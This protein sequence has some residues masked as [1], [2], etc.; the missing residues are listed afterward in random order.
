VEVSGWQ[1]M[2]RLWYLSRDLAISGYSVTGPFPE[3]TTNGCSATDWFSAYRFVDDDDGDL[4]NGTPHADLIFSAFDL[5]ATAC[6]AAGDASNQSTGCPAPVAAP[7]LS[8]VCSTAPVQLTWTA[9]AGAARYRVLRNTLGCEFG[10]TPLATVSAGRTYFEDAEVAPGVTYYYSVQPVSSNPSCYGFASSCLAVATTACSAPGLS[11]PGG[12]AAAATADNEVTVSWNPVAGA[13]SYKVLRT[14]G[15]CGAAGPGEAVGVTAAPAPALVDRDDLVGGTAYGYRVVAS[16]ASCPSCASEPSS[17]VE[18][19]ATGE[20]TVA[21]QFAGVRSVVS[22][23]DGTCRLSVGWDA[24]T[25]R[26]GDAL[27]YSVYRSTDPGFAPAP[28]NLVASEVAGTGW[29]DYGVA[30]DTRYFYLVRAVDGFGNGDTNTVRRYEVPA[31]ALAPGSFSDDAGDTGSGGFI[32]A[33]APP[34]QWAQRDSDTGNATRVDATTAAGNYQ[35][36][37]CSAL[38]SPTLRL[39]ADPDLAFTTRYA[40]EQGWDG[41]IVQV[42]TE[43]GGFADWTRLDSV[44]YPGAMT[45]PLGDPACNIPEFADLQPV[46]TGTSGGLYQDNGG[47]LADWAGQAVRLRFLFSSDGAT[48]DEGWFLDDLSVD[49]VMVAASCT[50]L[51]PEP[52]TEEIDDLDEAVSYQGGW[53]RRTDA[54]ATGGGYHRRVGSRNGEPAPVAELTFAGDSITYLYVESNRGGTADVLIDGQLVDTVVYGPGGTGPE[55]PTFGHSRTWSGLGPGSHRLEI[56][57]R[58]GTVYVD[59]FRFDCSEPGAG[60]DPAAAEYHSETEVSSGSSSEGLVLSR[61][62]VVTSLTEEVSVVV[63][64]SVVPLTVRL[65]GPAGG[66]LATGGALLA[67]GAVSGLDAGVSAP[68]TYTVQVLNALGAFSRVEI[69]VARTVRVE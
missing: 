30:P 57:H 22:A 11:P 33:F 64:G 31:G 34:S 5:H 3:G 66:L 54:R 40:I 62:I 48:T 47:T 12:V 24:G 37:A 13:A 56:R 32:A 44:S 53:H 36:S 29:D 50:P 10:F 46:F 18:V 67:G 41:G 7:T 17:C 1:T 63:E 59:G 9:S 8:A 45:G 14:A 55:N 19:E 26:C 15:G 49:D 39:G 61:T 20:C 65:R 42:A 23:T 52:C 16:D 21:P 58:T 38:E 43:A 68:G 69:S 27:T 28:G 25:A 4:G 35:D 51:D 6:G 60:A 2:D